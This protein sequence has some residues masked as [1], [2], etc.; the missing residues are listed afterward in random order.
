MYNPAEFAEIREAVIF[1]AAY[2]HSGFTVPREAAIFSVW[3]HYVILHLDLMLRLQRQ[4][5]I[6]ET[7]RVQQSLRYLFSGTTVGDSS[8]C[9]TQE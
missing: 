1:T 9:H 4:K 6:S 2:C 3:P 8:A 7:S 5:T